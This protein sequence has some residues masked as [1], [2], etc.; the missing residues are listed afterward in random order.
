MAQ[1]NTSKKTKIM[2]IEDEK[3]L[4]VLMGKKLTKEG[5]KTISAHDGKEGLRKIRATK[6]D[7]V[8]LDIVI[9]EK[10]GYEVLEEIQ[11]DPT[12]SK[13][14]VIVISSSEPNEEKIYSL[15]ARDYMVKSDLTPE[16]IILKIE[17]HL[18]DIGPD[19]KKGETKPTKNSG[20]TKILLIEDDE[21]LRDLCVTKLRKEGFDVTTAIDGQEGLRKIEK[22][23][24]ALILLDIILPGIDGFEVL[25]QMRASK[26][27][28][29]IPVILLTNLGQE[30]DIQK[31]EAL[32]A[33]DYLVKANF[34]TEEIIGKIK[35]ALKPKKKEKSKKP[36]KK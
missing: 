3:D 5:Y 8:L 10:N 27:I 25:K 14:P 15:G 23:K 32:G 34:T 24:P 2:I 31:G 6:P 11:N 13:I 28:A 17:A 36:T 30:T 4:L 33:Q 19:T 12:I 26:Q 21:I 18:N 1:N 22:E 7:L 16:D 9:P 35:K 29:R 20:G